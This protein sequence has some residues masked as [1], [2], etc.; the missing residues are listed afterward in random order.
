MI[1]TATRNERTAPQQL[2]LLTDS[3]SSPADEDLT[4]SN[5][6]V[7]FRL[8][9]TTRRRGLAHVAEIRQQLAE[10]QARRADA[11][12]RPLPSRQPQAA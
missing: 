2:T 10:A 11:Q 7:Q 6:P 4:V 1:S 9:T 12:S 5:A 8:S 3:P